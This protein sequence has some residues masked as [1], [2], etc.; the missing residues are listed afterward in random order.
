MKTL[1][2]ILQEVLAYWILVV[3]YSTTGFMSL[4]NFD[5]FAHNM[6]L[7]KINF[8]T[9]LLKISSILSQTDRAFRANFV[10]RKLLSNG[11]LNPNVFLLVT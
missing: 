11:C 2:D 5:I 10:L 6:S 8:D 9:Y 1:I 3:I 4:Y 7:S